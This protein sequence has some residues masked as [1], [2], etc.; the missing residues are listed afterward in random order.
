M[1][2]H[3]PRFLTMKSTHTY[4]PDTIQKE[5]CAMPFLFE[6]TSA[7]TITEEQDSKHQLPIV[8]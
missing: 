6:F 7:K 4:S 1:Q 5:T 8:T 3:L 2:A